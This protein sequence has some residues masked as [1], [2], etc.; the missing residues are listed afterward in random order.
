[1][2]KIADLYGNETDGK[3]SNHWT[4]ESKFLIN[5]FCSSFILYT[6]SNVKGCKSPMEVECN[7]FELRI[8]T[9]R[10]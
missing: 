5:E 10:G 1:M 3:R 8:W 7:L 4:C 6:I 9:D 2:S